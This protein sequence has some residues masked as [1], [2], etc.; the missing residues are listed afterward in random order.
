MDTVD[1]RFKQQ[2]NGENRKFFCVFENLTFKFIKKIPS[3]FCY[4]ACS[5]ISRSSKQRQRILYLLKTKQRQRS[6][7]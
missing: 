5:N 3:P 1:S 4:K 7:I 6:L 2:I